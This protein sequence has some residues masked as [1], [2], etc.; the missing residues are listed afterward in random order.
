MRKMSI[1]SW[2]K[3]RAT[4]LSSAAVVSLFILTSCYEA[5]LPAVC[6]WRCCGC[7]VDDDGGDAVVMVMVMG[8]RERGSDPK[9]ESEGRKRT[10]KQKQ[11]ARAGDK[12]YVYRKLD[13]D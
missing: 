11:D 1:S 8:R 9:Q 7:C 6:V 3:E 12:R 13:I 10:G 5:V 4:V 2:E